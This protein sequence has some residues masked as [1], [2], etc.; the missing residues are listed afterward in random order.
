MVESTEIHDLFYTFDLYRG[1][2]ENRLEY[3]YRGYFTEPIIEQLLLLAENNLDNT[4]ESLTTRKRLY[5][6]MVESLQNITRHQHEEHRLPSNKSGIFI[7]RKD[8]F[9]YHLTTGNLIQTTEQAKLQELITQLNSYSQEELKQ[10]Y[11]EILDH[12]K[13]SEKGGA[14]LGLI[15]MARKSGNK[16]QCDFRPIDE[17]NSYFYLNVSIN[18]QLQTDE[19]NPLSNYFETVSQIHRI[20]NEKHILLNYCGTFTDESQ[21]SIREI[22][23]HQQVPEEY[24]QRLLLVT[25]ELAY[26]IG[27]HGINSED[28]EADPNGILIISL[29]TEGSIQ[30]TTGNYV[31]NKLIDHLIMQMQRCEKLD[32]LGMNRLVNGRDSA[33]RSNGLIKTRLLSGER[34]LWDIQPVNADCS[35]LSIQAHIQ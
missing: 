19:L 12:G 13:L 11:R 31:S 3:I 29:T 34:L 23:K 35:F 33:K 30:I 18:D 17:E 22:I 26:N 9:R 21:T 4:P 7:I 2:R 32:D 14:G 5:F 6:L 15:G 20:V 10:R 24:G 16:L 28:A 27:Q 8:K 25:D 1:M